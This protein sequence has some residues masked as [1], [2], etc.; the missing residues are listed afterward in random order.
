MK[1]ACDSETYWS[2]TK[3]TIKRLPGSTELN[4]A[5]VD[6]SEAHTVPSCT[7][8]IPV[9]SSPSCARFF[10]LRLTINH[11]RK[12]KVEDKVAAIGHMT[13]VQDVEDRTRRLQ[14]VCP[15]SASSSGADSIF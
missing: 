9:R 6:Y 12:G 5:L 2:S 3:T 7:R 15:T 8:A 11:S 1:Q 13:S 10:T 4:Y 14:L